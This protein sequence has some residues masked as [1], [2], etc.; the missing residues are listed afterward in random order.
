MDRVRRRF[1]VS[2][3]PPSL[4]SFSPFHG[5]DWNAGGPPANLALFF[6]TGPHLEVCRRS[7]VSYS[8]VAC[9]KERLNISPRFPKAKLVPF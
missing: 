9:F 7:L 1:T 3:N 6:L 8:V 4:F 2:L 5:I